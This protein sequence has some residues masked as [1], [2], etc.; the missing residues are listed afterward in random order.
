MMTMVGG[1]SVTMESMSNTALELRQGLALT[2]DKDYAVYKE[3]FK[4]VLNLLKS[5][6]NFTLNAANR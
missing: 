5:N 4:D 3:G 2:E 6:E 1:S